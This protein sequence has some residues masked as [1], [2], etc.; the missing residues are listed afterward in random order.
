[1][2]ENEELI[3]IVPHRGKMFLL[4]RVIGYDLEER[5]MEAEYHVTRDCLFY[6][7][8]A[9]G[10]PSWVCFEFIAQTIGA[11]SGIRNRIKGEAPRIGFIVSISQ[12]KIEIPFIKT[13][14]IVTIKVKEIE[15]IDMLYVFTGDI[16]L[17]GRKIFEGKLT[18][19]DVDDEQAK[20]ILEER[21]AI[22]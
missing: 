19:I 12:V 14:S 4:S 6:D 20:T 16:F 7:S 21:N 18:V 2:I 5:T 1:M 8:S 17:E 11:L 13:G 9:D 22:G 3:S 10:I 15:S